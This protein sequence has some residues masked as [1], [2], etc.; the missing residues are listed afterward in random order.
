MSQ[1]LKLLFSHGKPISLLGQ[2]TGT[3]SLAA[4]R[5]AA[6]ALQYSHAAPTCLSMAAGG[7]DF[8]LHHVHLLLADGALGES[9]ALGTSSRPARRTRPLPVHDD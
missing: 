1:Q 6:I 5:A 4:H 7:D 3:H 9:A 2:G 8:D